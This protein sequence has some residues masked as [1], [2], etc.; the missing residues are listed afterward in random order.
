MMDGK[1]FI[2]SAAWKKLREQTRNRWKRDGRPCAM[3]G[4]PLDFSKGQTSVDHIE[5]RSKRP[6]LAL[7]PSNLAVICTSPC[8]NSTKQRMENGRDVPTIGAD[9]FPVGSEWGD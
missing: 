4:R 2:G 8:H 6:D 5:P 7:E 1:A 3:C 9:G